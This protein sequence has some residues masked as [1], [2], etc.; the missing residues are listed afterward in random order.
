MHQLRYGLLA[1]FA[2][3]DSV[4]INTSPVE[5]ESVRSLTLDGTLWTW[6]I[7]VVVNYV[8]AS[9]ASPN[10]DSMSVCKI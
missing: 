1:L 7:V 8:V 2:K 3:R 5:V 4:M 6:S 10:F 9:Y